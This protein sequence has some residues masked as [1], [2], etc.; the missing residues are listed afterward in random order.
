MVFY[1]TKLLQCNLENLDV[2]IYYYKNTKF[3]I[4]IQ[5]MKN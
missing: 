1:T 5:Q 3:Q 2:I 4:F